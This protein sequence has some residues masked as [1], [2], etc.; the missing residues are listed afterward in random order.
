M[1]A[2]PHPLGHAWL[3]VADAFDDLLHLPIRRPRTH[4]AAAKGRKT[5]AERPPSSAPAERAGVAMHAG[6]RT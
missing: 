1:R 4:I 6:S 3:L 5:T 2:E